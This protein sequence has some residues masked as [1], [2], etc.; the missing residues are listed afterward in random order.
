MF[1]WAL[2]FLVLLLEVPTGHSQVY[3]G[4]FCNHPKLSDGAALALWIRIRDSV[5]GKGWWAL[6]SEILQFLLA[7]RLCGSGQD[8]GKSFHTPIL[9]SPF[10]LLFLICLCCSITQLGLWIWWLWGRSFLSYH[11]LDAVESLSP[12]LK[13]ERNTRGKHDNSLKPG[14]HDLES[15]SANMTCSP[16]ADVMPSTQSQ[17]SNGKVSDLNSVHHWPF[18][19][20]SIPMQRGIL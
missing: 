3:S 1:S 9:T 5:Q 7:A 17:P 8:L 14:F 16:S 10:C 11:C 4:F 19:F 18:H 2:V 20:L 12:L 6:A 15:S 13:S